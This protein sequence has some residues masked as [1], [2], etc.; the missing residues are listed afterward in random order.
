MSLTGLE[1]ELQAAVEDEV[2]RSI[3]GRIAVAFE[4]GVHR[5]LLGQLEL[6]TGRGI[7]AVVVL[8]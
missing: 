5:H 8:L 3:A 2:L 4:F 6:R 7:E 1:A